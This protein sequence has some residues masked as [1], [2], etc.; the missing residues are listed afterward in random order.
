MRPNPSGDYQ[1]MIHLMKYA[2]LRP[3]GSR[4]SWRDSVDRLMN[5]L[6]PKI[7]SCDAYCHLVQEVYPMLVAKQV[8]P[9]MRLL[10]SAGAACDRE[11]L[12]AFNCMF[13][14]IDSLESFGRLMYALM[15]GTGVGFS[16][17]HMYIDK[18]PRVDSSLLSTDYTIVVYDNRLSWAVATIEFMKCLMDGEI[19]IVDYSMI[20][21]K[22]APLKTTGGY[23][24]GPEPLIELHRFI[25]GVF[26]DAQ[27]DQL[28]S[29]D[30][31]DI[32]CKIAD[33]VVQG[34]VRRSACICL[35]DGEDFNMMH[36]KVPEQLAKN[37][38]RTNA[39]NSAVFVD[40]DTARD[41]LGL[42]LELAR[43]TGEPGCVIKSLLQGRMIKSQR[44]PKDTIGVNPCGEIILRSNQVCN[45]TEVVLKPGLT[46][47][48]NMNQVEAAVLL[49][50]LQSQL[51]NFTLPLM[52]ELKF[53]TEDEGL[54]GVSLTGLLDDPELISGPHGLDWLR[55]HAHECAQKWSQKLGIK[56]PTAITCVKPSGTV[57]K[58]V[59]CSPGV[60]PRFSKY[61]LSNIG[62]AK[63]TPMA[64]FLSDSGVPVRHSM[65]HMSV[66]S[67]PM[68]APEGARTAEDL[69]AV[70]HLE[71][72]SLANTSWC[73]HNAS[74]TIYVEAHE[75]AEVN[76]WCR[77]N[78]H[79]LAGVTFLSKFTGI[80]GA[81]MPLEKITQ[82]EYNSLV[83][84]FPVIDW[85][86]F[87][88]YDDHIDVSSQEL[89]C[90]GGSCELI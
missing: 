87:P 47:E 61:Y 83:E 46:L 14:G 34:G 51:T 79:K 72:W 84:D 17:E 77:E 39:N 38:W 86:L 62:V 69:S 68:C 56:C 28:S 88:T 26:L 20:R 1:K 75:W 2:K 29:V 90:T 4:E 41:F 30:V 49:G 85:A 33:V 16:V 36:S 5:Y 76:S 55:E 12:T 8:M 48:D 53:N 71:L 24:S 59:D 21:A 67:F 78:T 25:A 89:A 9:S 23:A 43:D 82:D 15:C 10:S 42:L 45:L 57:S 22:G 13:L 54:L 63:G 50:L 19:P 32:C 6:L 80:G 35:F 60:H 65:S 74:C 52:E 81:Y 44:E 73:D 66:F 18:L 70:Q 40:E 11:N 27:G 58:L 37:P 64:R 31:Y 3:N 7:T